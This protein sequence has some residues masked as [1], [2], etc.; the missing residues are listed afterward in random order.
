MSS[1]AA[2]NW[3]PTMEERTQEEWDILSAEWEGYKRGL[4]D[5][6]LEH[7]ME[8]DREE[9]VF[10]LTRLGHS[11]QVATRASRANRDDQYVFCALIHD[12]GDMLG[13][14]NH[15]DIAA[16]VVKPFVPPEYTWMVEKHNIFQGYYF[17]HY[18][19][20]DRNAREQFRGH[21]WFDLTEEFCAEYDQPAFDVN[22]KSYDIEEFRPLV[23]QVMATPRSGS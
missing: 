18:V 22:Y 4:A 20:G 12:I 6:V 2:I 7:L 21:E 14:Y 9:S 13:T 3:A 16:A 1:Q 8:L 23:R 19:G 5:R 17:W 11:L 10:P 15:A